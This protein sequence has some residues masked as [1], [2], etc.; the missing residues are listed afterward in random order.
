MKVSAVVLTL[1]I[2]AAFYHRGVEA[3]VSKCY[4]CYFACSDPLEEQT[5]PN[6]D[7]IDYRCFS[8]YAE[9]DGQVSELKGCMLANDTFAI[10]GCDALDNQSGDSCFICD[11]DLCNSSFLV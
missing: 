8:V 5:C 6:S 7:L 1:A 11:T 4:Y 10:E 2:C 3:S 9:G